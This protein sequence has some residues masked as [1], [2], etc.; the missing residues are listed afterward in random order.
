LVRRGDLDCANDVPVELGFD[1][2]PRTN[3]QE[4]VASPIPIDQPV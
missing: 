3:H 1:P 4:I 2:L